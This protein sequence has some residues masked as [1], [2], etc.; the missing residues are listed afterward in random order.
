[1]QK[2]ANGLESAHTWDFVEEDG[3]SRRLWLAQDWVYS[4]LIAF[5]KLV[6]CLVDYTSVFFCFFGY[7]LSRYHLSLH[8]FFGCISEWE[9][10]TL[11]D[12]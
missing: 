12:H 1:M 3:C 6:I 9:N 11:R 7:L 4:N 2:G 8:K 5:V 10:Y